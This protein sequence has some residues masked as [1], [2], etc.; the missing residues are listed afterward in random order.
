MKERILI[1]GAAG[2]VGSHLLPFL[3]ANGYPVT[4]LVR[5]KDESKKINPRAQIVIGD[6]AEKGSW[7]DKLK[8]HHILIHLAAEIA[9]KT[10]QDFKRNNTLATRNLMEAAKRAKIKKV[11]LFSSAAVTSIRLDWY[12]KTKKQQEEIVAASKI[13]YIII[14]PSMIYGPADTKN[15]GWLISQ[16]KKLPIIPLPGG[17][18]FG[19]QPVYVADICKVVLELIPAAHSKKIYEIHG[20]EYVTMKEMVKVIKNALGLKK[21]TVVVPLFALKSAIWLGGKLSKNPKF[22]TDQIESLISGEKFS[23][24]KWWLIFDIIPTKFEAGVTKMVKYN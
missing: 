8:N 12:A 9:S 10:P 3:I 6:L 18:N 14:R 16:V 15:I 17:G 21:P 1:T 23:G 20:A 2:F 7:Q 19:R 11:I 5:T 13:P 22:T 4:A 24:D